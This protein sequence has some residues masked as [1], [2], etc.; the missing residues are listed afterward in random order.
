M[1]CL[2]PFRSPTLG[3]FNSFILFNHFFIWHGVVKSI[4]NY[5]FKFFFFQSNVWQIKYQLAYQSYLSSGI[6]ELS[7]IWHIRVI[8]HLVYQSHL[9]SDISELS[10]ICYNI[11]ISHLTYKSYISSGISESSL[12]WHIRVI[13]HLVYQSHLSSDT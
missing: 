1:Y 7:L 9:S 5:L 10:F 6:S 8:F 4:L 12:I 13:S 2:I 11:A 3:V